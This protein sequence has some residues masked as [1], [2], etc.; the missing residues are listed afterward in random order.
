MRILPQSAL[1]NLDECKPGELIRLRMW[2][3]DAVALVATSNDT[4]M[5]LLLN[6]EGKHSTPCCL[7]PNFTGSVLS[8][9]HA[10]EYTVDHQALVELK[11]HRLHEEP[12]ALLLTNQS[13]L[14]RARHIGGGPYY[15]SAHYDVE[16]FSVSFDSHARDAVTFTKWQIILQ[17]PSDHGQKVYVFSRERPDS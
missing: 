11:M 12:S 17:T 7:T 4:R 16:K 15:D 8:Y 1:K 9:G 5:L 6:G 13:W 3:H 14:V 2:Q 10:Y